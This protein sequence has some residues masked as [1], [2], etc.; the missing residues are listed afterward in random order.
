[1]HQRLNYLGRLLDSSG[2]PL[3]CGGT[4]LS[5]AENDSPVDPVPATVGSFTPRL[6]L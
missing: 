1:V 6:Q 3:P 5:L 4:G 2:T